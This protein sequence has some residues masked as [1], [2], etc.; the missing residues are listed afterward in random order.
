MLL[1]L[2][3]VQWL[4]Y[5][6]ANVSAIFLD[7]LPNHYYGRKMSAICNLDLSLFKVR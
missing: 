7:F 4:D 3:L 6:R 1:L 2:A 5:F